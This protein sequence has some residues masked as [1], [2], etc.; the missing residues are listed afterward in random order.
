MSDFIFSFLIQKNREQERGDRDHLF[1]SFPVANTVFHQSIQSMFGNVGERLQKTMEQV[2]KPQQKPRDPLSQ[3]LGLKVWRIMNN[4]P[5]DQSFKKPVPPCRCQGQTVSGPSVPGP[6]HSQG[7]GCWAC[8]GGSSMHPCLSNQMESRCRITVCKRL[9][10]DP[11][12]F[13]SQLSPK[14]KFW[15][16]SNFL[17]IRQCT[18]SAMPNSCAGILEQS[19]GAGNRV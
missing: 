3:K 18:A 4:H 6:S 19:M 2:Y 13:V 16:C 7:Q 12:N 9:T 1:N 8:M 15:T 5:S 14:C 11:I 17:R 10:Y